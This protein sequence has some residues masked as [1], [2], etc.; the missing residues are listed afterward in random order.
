MRFR[1]ASAPHL[2]SETTQSDKAAAA[3]EASTKSFVA[4][5]AA[6]RE[7]AA[8]W[9]E[10]ICGLQGCRSAPGYVRNFPFAS[11]VFLLFFHLSG[12]S[13]EEGKYLNTILLR[14]C[15]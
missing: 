11:S 4:A 6:E 15:P 7:K 10:T 3:A 13:G 14:G 5:A 1:P 12:E 8:V 9:S 2:S